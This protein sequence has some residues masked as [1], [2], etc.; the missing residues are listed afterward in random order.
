MEE[1]KQTRKGPDLHILDGLL[2]RG[3]QDAQ[4]PPGEREEDGCRGCQAEGQ[5]DESGCVGDASVAAKA[6]LHNH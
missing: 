2:A 1:V 4:C 3:R 5:E 6:F